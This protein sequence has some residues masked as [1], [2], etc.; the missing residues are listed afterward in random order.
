M[1]SNR[2]LAPILYPMPPLVASN[3][4]SAVQVTPTAID[5]AHTPAACL[6]TCTC[7]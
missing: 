1:A 7:S 2:T 3:Q 4:T 5:R 6:L